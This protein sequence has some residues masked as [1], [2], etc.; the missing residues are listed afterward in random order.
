MELNQIYDMRKHFN[1]KTHTLNNTDEDLNIKK[2][3]NV[4]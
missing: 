4:V 3:N 1:S 2:A